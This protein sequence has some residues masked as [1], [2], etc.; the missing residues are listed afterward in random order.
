MPG[1]LRPFGN[2]AFNQASGGL[3][4][5]R[6]PVNPHR[7]INAGISRGMEDAVW[8]TFVWTLGCS[9]PPFPRLMGISMQCL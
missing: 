9:T 6:S 3:R 2:F 1:L 4:L 7:L 5:V 8:K